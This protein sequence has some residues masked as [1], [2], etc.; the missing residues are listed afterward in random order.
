MFSRHIQYPVVGRGENCHGGTCNRRSAIDRSQVAAK[1]ARLPLRLVHSCFASPLM[2]RRHVAVGVPV[3][4]ENVT[5][6]VVETKRTP[7][8]YVDPAENFVISGFDH[9]NLALTC[10]LRSGAVGD[11]ADAR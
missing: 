1:H 5:E 11:V 9:G 10:H 4:L 2:R 7:M 6:R 8:A 3:N